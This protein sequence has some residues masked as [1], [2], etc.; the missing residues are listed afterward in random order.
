MKKLIKEKEKLEDKM[1]RDDM[2]K[3]MME[4]DAKSKGGAVVENP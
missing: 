2:V 4:K 3:R 1:A